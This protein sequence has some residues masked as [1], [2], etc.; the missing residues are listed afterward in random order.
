LA[1]FEAR[2]ITLYSRFSALLKER[3]HAWLFVVHFFSWFFVG[4]VFMAVP[5]FMA[6]GLALSATNISIFWLACEGSKLFGALAGGFLA[7]RLK[8]WDAFF[9][10]VFLLHVAMFVLVAITLQSPTPVWVF[11]LGCSFVFVF[12]TTEDGVLGPSFMKMITSL[13][14]RLSEQAKGDQTDREER[15]EEVLSM[16]EFITTVAMTLGPIYAGSVYASMGFAITVLIFAIVS[17]IANCCSACATLQL[18]NM[19]PKD[20]SKV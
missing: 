5:E 4:L 18:R 16:L 17:S 19:G 9:G 20:V 6:E 7:D 1:S 12:G 13:E 8:P 3:L 11:L 15:F 10:G 2:G 14:T